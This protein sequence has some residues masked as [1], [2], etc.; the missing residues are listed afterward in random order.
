MAVN[1]GPWPFLAEAEE[2]RWYGCAVGPLEVA[3]RRVAD[4]WHALTCLNPE[5]EDAE[6]GP[7]PAWTPA[8]DPPDTE[9]VRRW[10]V[11][12]PAPLAI[13]PAMPDRP[14]VVRPAASLSLLPGSAGSFRVAIPC[15]ARFGLVRG[16]GVTTLEETPTVVLSDT[17][18]GTPFDGLLC[19]AMRTTARRQMEDLLPRRHRAVCAVEVRN[20]GTEPVLLERLCIH[21]EHLAVYAGRSRLWTTAVTCTL[22]SGDEPALV[23]FAAGPPPHDGVAALVTPARKPQRSGF[24][25]WMRARS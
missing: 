13:L 4:E 19:Y 25:R 8:G 11:G 5:A 16:D 7:A 12:D 20:R 3:A 23:D 17:W 14:L 9:E 18:Y 21:A 2:G 10:L 22:R 1:P 15:W 6:P 24:L